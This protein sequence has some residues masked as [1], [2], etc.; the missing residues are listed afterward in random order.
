M[1]FVAE[2]W[3]EQQRCEHVRREAHRRIRNVL[4]VCPASSWS[5]DESRAVLKVVSGIVRARQAAGKYAAPH[6]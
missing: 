5:L 4:D 3:T 6:N 2:L 1:S